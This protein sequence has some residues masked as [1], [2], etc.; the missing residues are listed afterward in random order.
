MRVEFGDTSAQF[1]ESDLTGQSLPIFEGPRSE[2]FEVR[3]RPFCT[4]K[5]G[6]ARDFCC[7]EARASKARLADGSRGVGE[8]GNSN[9][10]RIKGQSSAL[11]RT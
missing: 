3:A 1:L 2:A 7:T 11:Q 9:E 6:L 4:M 10:K 8:Q 5:A